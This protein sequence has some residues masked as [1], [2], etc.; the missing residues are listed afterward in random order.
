MKKFLSLVFAF[1]FA[2]TLIGCCDCKKDGCCKDKDDC[3]LSKEK[4]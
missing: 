3:C 2:A 1:L 4:K